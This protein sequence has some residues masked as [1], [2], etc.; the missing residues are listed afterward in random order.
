LDV[1]HL[2]KGSNR[3]MLPH[4]QVGFS[5]SFLFWHLDVQKDKNIDIYCIYIY[6]YQQFDTGVFRVQFS[7]IPVYCLYN[8]IFTVLIIKDSDK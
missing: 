7:L 6:M 2:M 3:G 5:S 1:L 8:L 4:Q